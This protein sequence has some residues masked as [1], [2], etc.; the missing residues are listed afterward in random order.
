MRDS[1]ND[2]SGSDNDVVAGGSEGSGDRDDVIRMV[3][4][5]RQL[6]TLTE[7]MTVVRTL[8]VVYS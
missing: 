4:L 6:V 2:I 7:A 5:C 1:D 3:G 8:L